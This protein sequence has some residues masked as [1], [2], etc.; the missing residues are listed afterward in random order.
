[1]SITPIKLSQ[2]RHILRS[3]IGRT[4][5]W[6]AYRILQFD[7]RV[8]QTFSHIESPSSSHANR[9]ETSS[10]D[11][12]AITR[13][14]T[15]VILRNCYAPG[16]AFDQLFFRASVSASCSGIGHRNAHIASGLPTDRLMGAR[17]TCCKLSANLCFV[18]TLSCCLQ[19]IPSRCGMQSVRRVSP[20]GQK[21]WH[22]D[23]GYC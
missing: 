7:L 19:W 14:M 6:H 22:E 12:R 1:M 21:L 8:A 2:S 11:Y 23:A 20:F 3:D 13:L 16:C 17:L 18:W 15:K 10:N 4:S 5:P 9:A